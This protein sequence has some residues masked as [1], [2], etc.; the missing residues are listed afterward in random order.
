V[1]EKLGR[2]ED[3][4]GQLGKVVRVDEQIL[5][6]GRIEEQLGRLGRMEEQLVR[7]EDK[8]EDGFRRS[9]EQLDERFRRSMDQMDPGWQMVL[10]EEVISWCK[11]QDGTIR[12]DGMTLSMTNPET[13]RGSDLVCWRMLASHLTFPYF[14]I[15]FPTFCNV[16]PTNPGKTLRTAVLSGS[17]RVE[18]PSIVGIRRF[19]TAVITGSKSGSQQG[20][21]PGCLGR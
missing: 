16:S 6:L 8:V 5:R 19:E 12:Y 11:K 2:V 20:C 13:A 7:M 21:Q 4:I 15:R 3:Q 14:P 9:K 1:V 17:H 18:A 10:G